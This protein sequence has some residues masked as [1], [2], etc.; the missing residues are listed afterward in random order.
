MGRTVTH[1]VG[2][3]LNLFH[4]WGLSIGCE[5]DDEVDDTPNSA[6]PNYG[7]KIDHPSCSGIDMVENF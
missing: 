6:E 2:H 4:T 5:A 7:C 3:W 1:E